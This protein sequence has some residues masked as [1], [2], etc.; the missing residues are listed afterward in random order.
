[1]LH[2]TFN[3][4]TPFYKLWLKQ[5]LLLVLIAIPFIV[6]AQKF[7]AQISNNKVTVGE[8]VQISYTLNGNGSNFKPPVFK[9]FNVL[10]GPNQSSS[11]SIVNNSVSQ[12]V[13]LSYIIAATK[14]GKFTIGPASIVA[15]GKTLQSN[16]I[17]IEVSKNASSAQSQSS[18]Q[19]NKAG[20]AS[21]NAGNDVFVKTFIDKSKAYQGEQI[22]VTHKVYSRYQLVDLRNLKFPDYTGFWSQDVSNQ[23]TI[24]VTNENLDGVAYQV[25]ELKRSF[26]FAQRSGKMEIKPVEVE[27]V[28]RRQSRR[29]PRDVFEQFF[30]GGY[31]D[32]QIAAK[33]KTVTVDVLPLPK[34]DQ[35]EN[36]GG[37]VGDFSFKANL[38]K[39]KVKANDALNLTITISGQGNL[40]LIEP[41]K[42]NFPEDFEVYDPKIS[43]KITA[44]TSD[45]SGSKTFDYLVIP[46]H[47]GDYKIEP[48]HFS[49][50]DPAKKKY[51]SI[52]SP[53]FNI[54]VDKGDNESA[55]VSKFNPKSKEEVKIL[56]NDIRY[57][58]TGRINFKPV[59]D[60]FFG[61]PVFYIGL[62][63]PFVAFFMF[64]FMRK[65]YIAENSDIV[66]VKSRKATKMAKKRLVLAEQHLKLNN[67]ELFY[68]EILKAVFG[69]VG[70]KFNMPLSDLNK[71]NITEILK[72]KNVDDSIVQKLMEI[73]NNCEY[74]KYAPNAVS[75]DLMSIYSNTVETITKVEDEVR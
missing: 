59:D 60:Y 20:A 62:C 48:I 25:A 43:E 58:K 39:Q 64:V 46:R 73:V 8:N 4:I 17:A 37:A 32:V 26:L 50:F 57:I 10:S 9:D 68:S 11:V 24:Q 53:E 40:K 18:G 29:A 13:T 69:Y 63:S 33:G 65:K 35:P 49:F 75:S 5:A 56:G 28:I 7:T 47:E 67:K 55:T 16:A 31:E 38:S 51:I 19:N 44:G 22:T 52:P 42:I 3:N 54:H 74:A 2:F 34:A 72:R 1:M 45:V 15:D 41:Q 36:F 30:G 12:S 14:E 66:A 23:K 27:C 61:S 21:E 71:E 70:D 6:S